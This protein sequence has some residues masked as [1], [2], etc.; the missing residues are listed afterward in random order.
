MLKLDNDSIIDLK[1]LEYSITCTG[2]GAIG[3]A[4]SQ[5]QGTETNYLLNN[6]QIATLKNHRVVKIRFY[7]NDGFD[8]FELNENNSLKIQNAINLIF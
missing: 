2:C 3:F 5:I 8:E 4:G 1:N 7:T 6:V